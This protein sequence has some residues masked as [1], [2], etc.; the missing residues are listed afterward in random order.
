MWDTRALD[1]AEEVTVSFDGE[2][3]IYAFKTLLNATVQVRK[4]EAHR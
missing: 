1:I 4:R 3:G 2:L